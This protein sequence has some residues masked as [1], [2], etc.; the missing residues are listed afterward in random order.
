MSRLPSTNVS[1]TGVEAAVPELGA[2]QGSHRARRVVAGA[3]GVVLLVALVPLA[4]GAVG[5]VSAGDFGALLV[6]LL[7]PCVHHP[8]PTA[9]RPTN[10]AGKYHGD[11]T[12][13]ICE[14]FTPS[15]APTTDT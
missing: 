10:P 1:E 8:S 9:V 15:A 14:A 11:P 6:Y 13:H 7:F 2:V 3:L 4:V 12:R 5:A